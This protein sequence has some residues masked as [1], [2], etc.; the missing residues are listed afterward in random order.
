M[1]LES[2][3]HYFFNEFG[4]GYADTMGMPVSRRWRIFEKQDEQNRQLN[5]K[6]EA[7]MTSSKRSR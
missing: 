2:H 6:H 5:A 7:Q 1:A 3:L 4:I